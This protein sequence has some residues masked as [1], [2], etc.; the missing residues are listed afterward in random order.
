M[1]HEDL[2]DCLSADIKGAISKEMIKENVMVRAEDGGYLIPPMKI[3]KKYIEQE[4]EARVLV[5]K[6]LS[7]SRIA[8][9]EELNNKERRVQLK[10][11][12]F[13]GMQEALNK[14][15][16][17]TRIL[18]EQKEVVKDEA[19]AENEDV[20]QFMDQLNELT[21]VATPQ[22]KIMNNPQSK[23]Q[24]SDQEIMFLHHQ[25]EVYLMFQHRMYP[26]FLLNVTIAWKKVIQLEDVV[27]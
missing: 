24:D 11:E 16:E 21:N 4:L 1:F 9:K 7:P 12:E 14:M 8:E 23:N 26:S 27:N 13:T 19:P 2:F 6:R 10:E 20:K 22:K 17:L 5:T 15:K 25:T 18:K 3:L